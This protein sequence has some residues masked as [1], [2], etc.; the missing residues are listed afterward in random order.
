MQC[1]IR[2]PLSSNTVVSDFWHPCKTL[3]KGSTEIKYILE[4]KILWKTVSNYGRLPGICG[5]ILEEVSNFGS[6]F[7]LYYFYGR[8]G[9][10][11]RHCV[12][13]LLQLE[14]EAEIQNNSSA[15]VIRL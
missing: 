13:Q 3:E 5:E 2:N 8:L 1:K 6:E 12:A 10:V 14:Q 15:S 11:A 9:W 4:K 7:G